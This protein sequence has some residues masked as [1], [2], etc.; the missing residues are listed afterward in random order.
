L[1]IDLK[2]LKEKY[3]VRMIQWCLENKKPMYLYNNPKKEEYFKYIGWYACYEDK[4]F[5]KIPPHTR[6]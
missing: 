5:C 6:R 2:T 1:Y 4:G 3:P